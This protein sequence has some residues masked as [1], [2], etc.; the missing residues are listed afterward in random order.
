MSSLTEL[1]EKVERALTKTQRA[2]LDASA[3]GGGAYCGF[4]GYV[5]RTAR[6][7]EKRGLIV[8]GDSDLGPIAY[9]T[10]AGIRALESQEQAGG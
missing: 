6:S 4:N 1:R 9:A 3:H 7:L 10:D 2:F 8:I 5:R